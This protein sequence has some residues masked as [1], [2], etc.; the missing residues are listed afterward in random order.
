MQGGD[1]LIR[2]EG[3]CGNNRNSHLLL[4]SCGI[5][6]AGLSLF[7]LSNV[8][9]ARLQIERPGIGRRLILVWIG[10][11]LVFEASRCFSRIRRTLFSSIPCRKLKSKFLQRCCRHWISS[12]PPLPCCPHAIH[13]LPLPRTSLCSEACRGTGRLVRL[14]QLYPHRE[15]IRS[16]VH[17]L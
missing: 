3:S 7:G 4:L 13:L 16:Y 8:L 5:W 9:Y 14:G 6:R 2:M 11:R 10:R 15:E 17:R 1:C 12:L